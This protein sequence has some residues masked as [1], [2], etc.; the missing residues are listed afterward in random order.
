MVELARNIQEDRLVALKVLKLAD[1]DVE[2]LKK[3]KVVTEEMIHPNLMR[4]FGYYG[5]SKE[6]LIEMEF[7]EGGSVLDIMDRKDICLLEDEICEV[8]KQTL[9]G[10]A[11]LHEHKKIHRDIK[12]ANVMITHQ[13]EVKIGT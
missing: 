5:T 6:V 3:E 13:G 10:L 9:E 1:V 2:A 11:Y 7:C 8:A 12:A 4:Y